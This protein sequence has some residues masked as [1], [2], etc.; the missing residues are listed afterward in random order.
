MLNRSLLE[1]VE[2]QQEV[3]V[4]RNMILPQKMCKEPVVLFE[5]A[6]ENVVKEKCMI[7]EVQADRSVSHQKIAVERSCV[8]IVQ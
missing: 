3:E 2:S 7:Q 5:K 6:V 4:I 1:K 8:N